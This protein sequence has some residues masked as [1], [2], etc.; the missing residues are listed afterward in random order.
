M[1]WCHSLR[2][3]A[4]SPEIDNDVIPLVMK[5]AIKDVVPVVLK[6]II[7]DDASSS[8]IDI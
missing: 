7:H 1:V 8:G 6:L 3:D 5:L 2:C 4:N